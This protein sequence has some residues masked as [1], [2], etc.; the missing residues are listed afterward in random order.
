MVAGELNGD[1]K[2]DLVLADAAT[3]QTYAWLGNGDGR[4]KLPCPSP[5]KL[6]PSVWPTSTM[7]E[8]WIWQSAHHHRPESFWATDMGHSPRRELSAV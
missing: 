2:L 4:S 7:M 3:F 8:D 6:V 5:Q 1:G